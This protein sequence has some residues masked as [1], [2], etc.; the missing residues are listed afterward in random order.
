MGIVTK[1]FTHAIAFERIN[2]AQ[3]VDTLKW[4]ENYPGQWQLTNDY[5]LE[6]L[7]MT[8]TVFLLYTLKYGN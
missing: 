8:E 2:S 5:D 6:D 1:K 3:R 7:E 4:L